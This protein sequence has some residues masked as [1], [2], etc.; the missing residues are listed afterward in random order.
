MTWH[1]SSQ[2]GGTAISF[3]KG[4]Y[5][6][7]VE[8][9]AFRKATDQLSGSERWFPAEVRLRPVADQTAEIRMF[10]IN[11][12]TD[13]M[14]TPEFL[15]PRKSSTDHGDES[16]RPRSLQR[17]AIPMHTSRTSRRIRRSRMPIRSVSPAV[18][19]RRPVE[20]GPSK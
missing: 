5:L 8:T 17:R 7:M 3:P 10:L 6:W 19:W 13:L 9:A 11:Q 14:F 4:G 16:R 2:R 18:L 12:V 15:Q 20:C 1:S